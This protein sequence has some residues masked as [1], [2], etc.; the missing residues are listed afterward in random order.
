MGQEGGDAAEVELL[1][2]RTCSSV[3]ED[4][5]KVLQGFQVYLLCLVH[6]SLATYVVC[7]PFTSIMALALS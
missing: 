1:Y 4:K 6:P 2:G 5:H 3:F 7:A